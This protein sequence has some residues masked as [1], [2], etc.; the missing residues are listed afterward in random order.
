MTKNYILIIEKNEIS[1]YNKYVFFIS[2]IVS[3][4]RSD[5]SNA[6]KGSEKTTRP[7]QSSEK[8]L[9]V[10]ELLSMQEEP[11]KLQ[12]LANQLSMNVST[13]LRFLTA[14]QNKGYVTQDADSGRYY[15]TY[16]ICRLA[17]R[18]ASHIDFR[19]LAAPF[20]R[21]ISQIFGESANLSIEQNHMVV[22]I[23]VVNGPNQML[24]TLQRIGNIAPLHCTGVGKLFLLNYS[25]AQIDHL[26]AQKGLQKFTDNTLTTKQALLDALDAARKNGYAFD[27][28]ECEIGARCVAAPIR[29]FSGKVVAALSVSG[30][31]TR[32]TD[33][34]IF[35]KLPF[36]LDAA[37][38]ISLRL[39][40]QDNAP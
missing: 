6:M 36:L 30:P 11:V 13:V 26:I 37:A 2:N 8:L 17:N 28:E 15:L 27:N 34:L 14:L 19:N 38:Q 3:K 29:D 16:K 31:S 18:V 40:F 10:M 7:N 39:G 21:S 22:Y 4:K 33:D 5:R 24:T 9:A 23:E 32:M 12:T 20:L 25:V 35:G 1:Y